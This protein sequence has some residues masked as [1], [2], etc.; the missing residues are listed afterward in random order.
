MMEAGSGARG[1]RQ[2]LG[3]RIDKRQR[4]GIRDYDGRVRLV[5]DGRSD[6]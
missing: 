4:G 1:M 5:A 6:G 2:G 3:T